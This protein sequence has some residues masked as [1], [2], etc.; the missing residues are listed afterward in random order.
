MKA[1]MKRIT[2]LLVTAVLAVSFCAAPAMAENIGETED[3]A[4][5]A[6]DVVLDETGGELDICAHEAEEADGDIVGTDVETVP[7]QTAAD[8]V[9]PA[10]ADESPDLEKP[11]TDE[12]EPAEETAPAEED[13][14]ENGE[15]DEEARRI[16]ELEA[17]FAGFETFDYASVRENNT[18]VGAK[19]TV[20]RKAFRLHADSGS[21]DSI[22]GT[23]LADL[24]EVQIEAL[25]VLAKTTKTYDEAVADARTYMKDRIGD[26][27][28]VFV[29]DQVIN[30][31]S[32]TIAQN[33]FEAVLAHTGDPRE[34]DYLKWQ[35]DGYVFHPSAVKISGKYYYTFECSVTY[36]DTAEQE[37]EVDSA[38][39]AALAAMG[40]ADGNFHTDYEK[41]LKIYR[42][43]TQNVQY[44]NA[45]SL[46]GYSAYGAMVLNKAVC[47]GYS[48][49]IYRL[50]LTVG[51]DARVVD[52]VPADHA[53]NI[54]KVGSSY[55]NLDATWDRNTG[56][57]PWWTNFLCGDAAH[58]AGEAVISGDQS[59]RERHQSGSYY[60]PA[61]VDSYNIPADCYPCFAAY[62]DFSKIYP[63]GKYIKQVH[64]SD[65]Q[66]TTCVSDATGCCVTCGQYIGHTHAFDCQVEE[67]EFLATAGNC[68]TLPTYYYSCACGEKDTRTFTGTEY[69]SHT[70]ADFDDVCDVCST[71]LP[72]T[73]CAEKLTKV[74]AKNP[75]CTAAGNIE[76]YRCTC[77]KLY[78]AADMT[79][80]TTA[81]AVKLPARGHDFSSF[82]IKKEATTTSEGL[83]VYSCS[84]CTATKEEVIPKISQPSRMIRVETGKNMVVYADGIA[85]AMDASGNVEL[86]SYDVKV[87]T[88]FTYNTADTATNYP[89][90]TSMK[91]YFISKD[92]KG[93]LVATRDKSFDGIMQYMGAS[94]RCDGNKGIRIITGI[95]VNALKKLKGDGLNGWK[96]TEYG[97]IVGN[98][99]YLTSSVV[100]GSPKTA[101]ATFNDKPF[102]SSG[103]TDSYTVG[104]TF[105]DMAQCKVVFSMRPYMKLTKGSVSVVLYGGIVHRSIGYVAWQ[106][107]N[108][109]NPNTQP[110][111]YNFIQSIIK[112][113]GLA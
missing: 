32:L 33:F 99:A 107:R 75:T 111:N 95:P 104:L 38:V 82:V 84:R 45:D 103:S 41:I 105:N 3:F 22:V 87:V 61:W 66:T 112:Y 9:L 63:Y 37:A 77:G 52:S 42:Y 60:R 96:L 62:D 17:E 25:R 34:G 55:Y 108:A 7:A 98:D 92:K 35:F 100:F 73:C 72:H 106:N 12:E 21:E 89:E 19:G 101:S 40:L 94:V 20:F 44:G 36:Y 18:P 64:F 54:V 76:H 15:S 74:P 110:T 86:P 49:A 51:L 65:N 58:A 5:L 6:T 91:V 23:S 70:D 24:N 59:F 30:E 68:V 43:V 85:V 81:E 46:I 50:A 10:E 1:F 80:E 53:W 28:V 29:T 47:Q 97:T 39:S 109:Y 57:D 88:T 90:Q 102:A 4:L 26:F 93:N 16:E 27:D 56:T 11:G 78:T 2:A 8:D 113:C 83:K 13:P 67:G 31:E 14:A 71:K 79:T 48:L 69:G